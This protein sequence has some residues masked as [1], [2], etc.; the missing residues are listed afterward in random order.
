[1]NRFYASLLLTTLAVLM[2]AC[3]ATRERIALSTQ[4]ASASDDRVRSVRLVD[5]SSIE[6]EDDGGEVRTAPSLAVVGVTKSGQSIT[7]DAARIATAKIESSSMSIPFW[8]TIAAGV[9][10]FI[11]ISSGIAG[12]SN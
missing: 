1:M 2:S 8:W 7:I 3:S 6:F 9:C 10:G 5:G 12:A 4:L 11:A